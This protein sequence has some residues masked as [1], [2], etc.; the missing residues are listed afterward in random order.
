MKK[1]FITIFLSCL[2]CSAGAQ[3]AYEKAMILNR[4]E[5][6]DE[7]IKTLLPLGNKEDTLACFL[8]GKNFAD[9]NQQINAVK[10]YTVAARKGN[11][12]AM[13]E[14]GDLYY[15]GGKVVRVAENGFTI[16]FHNGDEN[17]SDAKTMRNMG[18]TVTN[19]QDGFKKDIEQA[20]TWWTK[21]MNAGNELAMAK[22][23]WL[24]YTED[25]D[26]DKA[27]SILNNIKTAVIPQ[28]STFGKIYDKEGKKGLAFRY[29]REAAEYG[30]LDSQIIVA[31]WL[32]KG[33]D[34][35]IDK[36]VEEAMKWYKK[37]A[38][39][40]HFASCRALGY[41]YLK[42]YR[43]SFKKEDFE[44]ALKWGYK[45]WK[46]NEVF[47]LDLMSSLQSY[48]DG[49]YGSDITVDKVKE[50]AEKMWKES[51]VDN[52]I[53]VNKGNVNKNT[54][55]LVISNEKY[56]YESSVPFASNDGKVFSEY[57]KMTLG[58]PENNIH[59]INNAS[60][61]RMRYEVDWLAEIGKS[62]KN[63]KLI[64]YY[65]GHGVPAENQS[66]SYLLPVDGYARNE[67][68]GYDITEIYKQLGKTES[69]VMVILDAC[70]SGAKRDGEMLYAT[71]GVAIKAK[72]PVLT[73][74]T[75]VLSACQ[76]TET[77]IPYTE[78]LHGLFTY[79]LL[80][81]IQETKGLVSYGELYDYINKNVQKKSL[82][83]NNKVQ[84][85]TIISSQAVA[86]SWQNMKL[87]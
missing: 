76:G 36:D 22:L 21:A 51:D 83:I 52:Y 41:Y 14:L 12:N 18:I 42:Q 69:N 65:V 48:A 29:Y 54:W 87:K 85:P 16:T 80:K 59:T 37:A 19:S 5:N 32:E 34:F 10:W 4:Q 72:V 50:I 56:E 77:A 13:V 27:F 17:A 7:A 40:D 55:V 68:S 66:T 46:L 9:K 53:P 63:S 8:L 79:Y 70:F 74:N 57:C 15:Y 67:Q 47:S 38:L 64:L 11:T 28:K 26:T 45:C 81:K 20:R 71:R 78:Q 62:N 6:Y 31:E 39:K 60:L 44:E 23:A 84:T 1:T 2:F 86:D 61:N 33:V 43:K 49:I 73:G 58:I 24:Y 3:P 75:V 82:D 30:D 25:F 35:Y